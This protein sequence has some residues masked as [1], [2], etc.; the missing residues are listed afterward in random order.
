[1]RHVSEKTTLRQAAFRSCAM[2]A[3]FVT[4]LRAG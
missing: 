4:G 3:V 2:G 1:M